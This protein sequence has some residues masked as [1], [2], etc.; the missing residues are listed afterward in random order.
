[1]DIHNESLLEKFIKRGAWLYFFSFL[2]GP[3]GYA[4]KITVSYDL[5]VSDV[6]M[7]Y[8]ILSFVYLV[9]SFNDFGMIESLN[10]FIPKLLAKNE[11]AKAK[12][13]ITYAG[14][15]MLLSS[16][17]VGS[18]LLLGAHWLADNYFKIPEAG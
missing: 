10:Y 6:G 15:A 5:S 17:V 3:I 14:I 16:F 4:I 11:T 7:L 9:A 12:S 13:F 8:G 2:I 18:T 1:M